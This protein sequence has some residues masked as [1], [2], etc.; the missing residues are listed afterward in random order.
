MLERLAGRPFEDLAAAELFQPLGLVTAGF[1]PPVGEVP[2]GHTAFGLPLPPD[3]DLYPPVGACPAGLFRMSLPEWA[4]Y[5]IVHMGLWPAGLSGAGAAG[6]A[7]SPLGAGS[8]ADLRPGLERRGGQLGHRAVAQRHRRLLV[9]ADPPRAGAGLWRP[10]G[11]E[12]A[13]PQCRACGRGAG[14]HAHAALPAILVR[15]GPGPLSGAVC[16]EVP[17]S[18]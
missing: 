9:G 1:G 17:V 14:S 13:R 4:R 18:D 7:A 12:H 11:R 2:Q 5:A 8:R 6:A 16:I 15:R 10:D 3:S